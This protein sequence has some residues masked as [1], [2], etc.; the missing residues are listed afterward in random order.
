MRR[1]LAQASGATLGFIGGNLPGAYIGYKIGSMV[2]AK[3]TNGKRKSSP[4]NTT[5]KTIPSW[6]KPKRQTTKY[7]SR[8]TNNNRKKQFP[9]RRRTYKRSRSSGSLSSA[10]A[11]T[12]ASSFSFGSGPRLFSGF[13][14]TQQPT[15]FTSTCTTRV[16]GGSGQQ[17]V[18]YLP[19]YHI[20]A[21]LNA[22]DVA[23][24][25]NYWIDGALLDR[26]ERWLQAYSLAP[27]GFVNPGGTAATFRAG[28]AQTMKFVCNYLKYDQQVRNVGNQDVTITIYDVVLRS[29]VTPNDRGT[30]GQNIVDP[31]QDWSDGLALETNPS[32][33]TGSLAQPRLNSP[34]TTPFHSTAF[35][36][37]YKIR[38]VT[39]KTL[40]SG[41]VHHHRITMKPRNMFDNQNI[42]TS[43]STTPG[44]RDRQMCMAG[45]TGL[46]IITVSGSIVNASTTQTNI[47]YS[48]A[49]IDCVTTCSGSF[50]QYTRERRMHMAFD[51]LTTDANLAAGERYQ[52]PLDDTDQIASVVNA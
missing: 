23:Y 1:K 22:E 51:G 24:Q 25:S 16:A 2:K 4:K 28:A 14:R 38:R 17:A 3:K 30:I 33:Q 8:V 29:G 35:C 5:R 19:S 50:S 36:K 7:R 39:K 37:L 31:I 52:A 18:S 27:E 48:P 47:T 34:G 26:A 15:T 21:G 49:V 45:L 44:L 20:S 6:A 43:P 12:S 46:S 32:N 40:A 11:K 10:I 13:K 42:N 41:E 9:Q